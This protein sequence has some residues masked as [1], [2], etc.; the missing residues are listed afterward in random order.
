MR[1][2]LP[3]PLDR[4]GRNLAVPGVTQES[5]LVGPGDRDKLDAW[6]TSVREL[7]NRLE[8]QEDWVFK[9]KPKISQKELVPPDP[10]NAACATSA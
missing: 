10:E 7:E 8:A 9:P 6:F 4:N 1:R 2:I 5:V 3:V